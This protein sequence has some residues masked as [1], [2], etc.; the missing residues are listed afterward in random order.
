M[1]IPTQ[2][3]IDAGYHECP[4]CHGWRK[5]TCP[6]S[7]R[8]F[9]ATIA[10]A[11]ASGSPKQDVEPENAFEGAEKLL[12][13]E[14]EQYCRL[15]DLHTIHCRTDMA[16]TISVGHP[17]FAVHCFRDGVCR[18]CFVEFKR[19]G[20]KLKDRQKDVITQMRRIGM[21]VIVAWTLD[22]AIEFVKKQFDL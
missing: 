12:H 1:S 19:A 7:K 11:T 10:P 6:C 13:R 9:P 17:D 3:L 8:P 16:S 15:H 2:S 21:P 14:F 22:D 4:S 18:A 5:G 20:G